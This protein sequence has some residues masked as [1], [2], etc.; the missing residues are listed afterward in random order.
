MNVAEEPRREDAGRRHDE[1]TGGD[2]KSGV[3]G[4]EAPALLHP[5]DREQECRT[6]ST[7]E[8]KCCDIDPREG[9]HA[10]QCGVDDGVGV[11][12]RKA[13][14]RQ[15]GHHGGA[16]GSDGLAGDPTPVIGLHEA[17]DKGADGEGEHHAAEQVRTRCAFVVSYVGDKA[18]RDKHQYDA[19][20]HVDP[21]RP[22]P[23]Q[24]D[25]HSTRGGAESCRDGTGER[26]QPGARRPA[27]LRKRSEEEAEARRSHEGG[28]DGLC[29]T[30]CDERP[31]SVRESAREAGSREQPQPDDEAVLASV[32]VG[33]P[34]CRDQERSKHDGVGGENPAQRAESGRV[35]AVAEISSDVVE[36]HVHDEQIETREER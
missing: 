24:L 29:G 31:H 13:G 26:P 6:E 22:L 2:R 9:P 21:E 19:D 10:E 35:G 32:A 8:E 30:E 28:A 25:E 1:R 27:V 16:E 3:E 18:R 11:T 20:R 12:P 34:A 5:Q 33:E 17:E 36:C 15:C 14:E 7:V 4:G 23:G